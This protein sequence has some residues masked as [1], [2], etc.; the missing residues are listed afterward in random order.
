MPIPMLPGLKAAPSLASW[1][2]CRK[3]ERLLVGVL[4]A[5]AFETPREFVW[6]DASMPPGR[7]WMEE[8][9]ALEAA[10][11]L[12]RSVSE[13]LKVDPIVLVVREGTLECRIWERLRPL[14][15]CVAVTEGLQS[16]TLRWLNAP[17]TSSPGS[18]TAV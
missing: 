10:G 3:G 15:P 18:R 17:T 4:A 6:N 16:Q 7:A 13:A 1:G 8:A 2:S 5:D 12:V 11:T 9:V 14:I